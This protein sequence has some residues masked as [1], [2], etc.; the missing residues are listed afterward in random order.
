MEPIQL[1]LGAVSA[2]GYALWKY[3]D[4]ILGLFLK[5]SVPKVD[6]EVSAIAAEL[7]RLGMEKGNIKPEAIKVLV[8]LVQVLK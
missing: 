7:V 2:I 4:K 1:I 8:D 5:P 6:K 3:K